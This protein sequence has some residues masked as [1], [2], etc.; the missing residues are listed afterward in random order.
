MTAV[1][2]PPLPAANVVASDSGDEHAATLEGHWEGNIGKGV[3]ILELRPDGTAA[4]NLKRRVRSVYHPCTWHVTDNAIQLRCT[5]DQ[6]LTLP[7]LSV[8]EDT[9]VLRMGL[10]SPDAC[11]LRRSTVPEKLFHA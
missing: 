11:L 4:I 7:I 5:R 9:M 6:S 8:A 1:L 3:L 2:N 10:D